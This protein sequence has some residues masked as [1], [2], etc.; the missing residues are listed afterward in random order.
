[1]LQITRNILDL[2]KSDENTAFYLK[3][4]FTN[5]SEIG[6][7][8]PYAKDVV[9]NKSDGEPFLPTVDELNTYEINSL[10]LRGTIDM[11][12]DVLA[13]GCS[14]TF[15]I[16]VPE[17]GRWTDILSNKMNKSVT[18]LG[19]PGASVATICNHII[20]YCMNNKMP[21]EIFCLMPDFVRSM[22]VVDKE[23]YK[24]GVKREDV[25]KEDYLELMFCN[26]TIKID[27]DTVYMET[28]NKRNIEDAISPHQ[29]ILNAVN[30]IYTLESFC[31]SNNIK[32]YWTTWNRA[33]SMIMRQ[34]LMLEDFKLKNFVPFYPT[35][36]KDQLD[37]FIDDTCN[38]DHNSEFK[39]HLCWPA[40]SDY[41]IIDYKK[42]PHMHHPG[43]HFQ[44]HIADFFYNLYNKDFIKD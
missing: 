44:Y 9:K 36:A 6:Y 41:S 13:S 4:Y 2:Y 25:G 10:G 42:Q 5:T 19:N 21:K 16:G 15:G 20:H 11:N 23:F 31:L 30:S 29:L 32:L 28:K 3:K 26:P 43:I 17:E 35:N 37:E 8:A 14:I 34:L 18:N 39:D 24:S 40:A 27:R 1:M 7:Y 38:S 22:V 12:S 33:S